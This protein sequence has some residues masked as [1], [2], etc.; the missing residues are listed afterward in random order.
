MAKMSLDQ[1]KIKSFFG[2][3]IEKLVFAG[4]IVV[5]A[6]FVWMGYRLEGVQQTPGDL[7]KLTEAT[8]KKMGEDTWKSVEEENRP[9]GQHAAKA[10]LSDVAMSDTMYATDKPLKPVGRNL[11]DKR[12][13]PQLFAPSK[14]EVCE[15]SG[16]VAFR[17]GVDDTDPLAEAKDSD[18]KKKE[19]KK[20]P[21]KKN[22]KKGGMGYGPEGMMP[23]GMSSGAE[24]GASSSAGMPPMGGMPP[25]A[26]MPPMGGMEGGYGSMGSMGGSM[27]AGKKIP[28][29]RAGAGAIAK[30]RNVV[31]VKAIVELQK[32]FD[33]YERAFSTSVG[34]LPARDVPRFV[35][36]LAQRA[37]VTDDPNKT[38]TDADW[39][40]IASNDSVKAELRKEPWAGVSQEIV[41]PRYVSRVLTMPIPPVMMRDIDPLALHSLTPRRKITQQ[42]MAMGDRG[43]KKDKKK[44]KEGDAE[45]EKTAVGDAPTS[46]AAGSGMSGSTYGSGGAMGYPGM[47]GMG[48]MMP[49][50]AAGGEEGMGMGMG[51]YPG[52]PGMGGMTPG[53]GAGAEEPGM[54]MGYPGMPGMGGMMPPGEGGG[55]LGPEGGMGG[56]M[57]G[58]YGMSGST[59]SRPAA[60]YALVRFFDMSA[61]K[62]HKY[63]YRIAVFL[64]DP[65]HPQVAGM[66][67]NERDLD[68]SVKNRLKSV[69]QEDKDKSTRTYWVRTD[70]SSPSDVLSVSPDP[71]ALAGKIDNYRPTAIPNSTQTLPPNEP[72]GTVMS[73]VWDDARSVDVPGS[74]DVYRGTVLN[75]KANADVIHP[76]TLRYK[77]L[78]N[79]DFRTDNCVVDIRGGEDLPGSDKD[80]LGAMGE[81]LVLTASGELEVRDELQDYD[82]FHLHMPPEAPPA[83]TTGYPGGMEGGPP[84]TDGGRPKMPGGPGMPSGGKQPGGGGRGRGGRNTP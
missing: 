2:L 54:A 28:G 75:F 3:H 84:G 21:P 52:M 47:P 30:S 76:V 25:M 50:M 16:P 15:V 39:Q 17:M 26:G 72:K 22:K 56:G 64:E 36:F 63:R 70:W 24:G 13:D 79:F 51:G 46:G 29:F 57:Y 18:G 34:Y 14:L 44:E 68:D 45:K 67:P 10:K 41:D 73:V 55:M 4:V 11:G 77:K 82:A 49:G 48:G 61:E 83:A 66:E 33:E 35:M 23:P 43:K 20:E 27:A 40:N 1:D 59:S 19:P 78:E 5:L 6:V 42:M 80:P 38:L 71:V 7:D 32:Q 60:E 31:S 12:K 8:V 62:G 37:D 69:V 81:Y 53:M 74:I 9:A 58:G 65:N